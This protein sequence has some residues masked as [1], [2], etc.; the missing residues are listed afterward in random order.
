MN[1]N[2]TDRNDAR[3][4]RA[5]R[6][7]ATVLCGA[8]ALTLAPAREAQA[9][10]SSG[11]TPRV[12]ATGA[13][14]DTVRTKLKAEADGG[15]GAGTPVADLAVVEFTVAPGGYFGWHVHGGPVWVVVEQGTLT[16]YD[17]DDPSCTGAPYPEGSALLDSGNHVHN[18][19]NEGSEP[20]VIYATFMLPEGGAL[21]VDAPN[22]G[23]CPF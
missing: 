9:T 1:A 2:P 16:L 19:R 17:G 15:F 8:L 12:I 22:P 3:P 23:L 4:A 6:L 11:V 20:V 18:A 10:P 7:A 21:R 5:T 14:P 13:L